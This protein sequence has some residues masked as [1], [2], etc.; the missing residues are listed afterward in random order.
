MGG[1]LDDNTPIAVDGELSSCTLSTM[2]GELD[3][4]TF[5]TADSKLTLLSRWVTTIFEVQ[6]RTDSGHLFSHYKY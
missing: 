4:S 3:D 5:T 6:I 2:D 1:K